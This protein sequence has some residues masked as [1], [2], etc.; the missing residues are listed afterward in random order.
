MASKLGQQ[1]SR[2]PIQNVEIIDHSDPRVKVPRIRAPIYS[3]KMEQ[4]A[5]AIIFGPLKAQSFSNL[6]HFITQGKIQV[7][8]LIAIDFS[9]ANLTFETDTCLHS[10]RTDK[11]NDYRDIIKMICESYQN[12]Y[13]IPVFGY[14][15]KTSKAFPC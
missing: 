15:A 1:Q 6:S 9:L 12:N 11:P 5:Y 8:P 13:N 14:S 3:S 2:N 10:T 7:V 4:I